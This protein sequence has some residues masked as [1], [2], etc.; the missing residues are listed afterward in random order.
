VGGRQLLARRGDGLED[1]ATRRAGQVSDMVDAVLFLE[2]SPTARSP[3][4][5][6]LAGPSSDDCLL[7]CNE[8]RDVEGA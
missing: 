7:L 3:A 6:A 5:T 8:F 1:V 4:T 2:S